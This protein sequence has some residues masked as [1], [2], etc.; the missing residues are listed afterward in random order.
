MADP[1]LFRG[2]WFLRFQDE[3]ERWRQRPSAARTKTEAKRLQAELEYQVG[4][5]RLGL[6]GTACTEL[7]TLG[8][9][10]KRWLRETS[11]TASA[12]KN[13]SAV[14]KHLLGEALAARRLDQVRT[15][16]VNDLIARKS[17]EGLA[18]Q[19][20]NHLRGFISRAYSMAIERGWWTGANPV[21]RAKKL[22]I[23][24]LDRDGR[25][26]LRNEEVR[27]LL[28]E[29]DTHWR[30]LFATAIFGG[31]RKGELLA[32]RKDAIDFE[33]G[34]IKVSRSGS[35]R[36]TKSGRTRY[37]PI[38]PELHPYLRW[39][40][41]ASRSDLV[42][43]GA[44][45]Q[46]MRG[47]AKLQMVLR[48]ALARAGLVNG[49]EH[50]CRKHGCKHRERHPDQDQR[51]CPEHKVILWPVP[52]AQSDPL[53]GARP[54][55]GSLP[56]PAS[57]GRLA[58]PR[59]RCRP[60]HRPAGA[61]TRRRDTT[62][63]YG[64]FALDHEATPARDPSAGARVRGILASPLASPRRRTLE[65]PG[66]VTRIRERCR[67]L[68]ESGRRGSNPRPSAWEADALPLSYSR[69]RPLRGTTPGPGVQAGSERAS[70]PRPL[71]LDVLLQLPPD[72]VR[73][74]PTVIVR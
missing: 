8:E 43:P 55:E 26:W 23:P 31:L 21:A 24:E 73:A 13:A 61:R 20:V 51:R 58:L 63:R 47:D 48:R 12:S 14:A 62:G 27:A 46:M 50:R 67:G 25:E 56:R 40:V 10:L 38:H 4:R 37:V 66:R 29:L 59:G 11:S 5:R 74:L 7:S 70:K 36:T 32:L 6:E 2:R 53:A 69:E 15:T 30:P 34:Y 35:R 19:T 71:V 1:F 33:V 41:D 54:A 28:E 18:P 9:L 60:D 72:E 49:F 39:A 52:G 64:H 65:G 45:G 17:T 22:A 44:D 57:H 42:F 3:T 16:D 68:T